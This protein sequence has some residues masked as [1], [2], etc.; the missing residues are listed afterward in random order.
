MTP[1]ASIRFTQL[2]WILSFAVGGFCVVYYFIIRKEQLPIIA[3]RIRGVVEGRS[4]ETYDTA[5]DIIFWCVF[6]VMVA[7]LIVQVTLLVSFMSRRAG[8]RWWQLSTLIVQVILL[9]ISLELVATGGE[10][11][12]LRQL[13]PLQCGLVLLGLLVSTL[14]PAIAWTARGVDVRRGPIG[15]GSGEA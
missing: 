4:D 3:D 9:A 2:C 10:G 8:I 7:V 13:L 11:Q 6:G 12:I 5:A 15:S 1:P 14:P